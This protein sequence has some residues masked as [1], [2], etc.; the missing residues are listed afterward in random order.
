MKRTEAKGLIELIES[1]ISSKSPESKILLQL[2]AEMKKKAPEETIVRTLS[3][4]LRD[5]SDAVASVLFRLLSPGAATI[6][7]VAGAFICAPKQGSDVRNSNEESHG[8]LDDDDT[9]KAEI[10]DQLRLDV[11]EVFAAMKVL[12]L[13]EDFGL[14]AFHS[15]VI[16]TVFRALDAD[17][18]GGG[19]DDLAFQHR[20]DI[21]PT[22]P[23]FSLTE[24]VQKQCKIIENLRNH[25]GA[26]A[27]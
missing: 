6:L 21:W 16:D 5:R 8:T 19:L 13:D 15:S 17:I 14:V 12:A 1:E 7:S 4:L 22:E 27:S 18:R 9:R 11:K 3:D 25:L 2:K 20:R 10:V 24:L 23:T 26:E